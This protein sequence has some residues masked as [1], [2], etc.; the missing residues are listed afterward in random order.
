MDRPFGVHVMDDGVSLRTGAKELAVSIVNGRWHFTMVVEL[1]HYTGQHSVKGRR[2]A[3]RLAA[4][5]LAVEKHR[6]ENEQ[7]VDQSGYPKPRQT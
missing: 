4:A 7:R 6:A 5:L 2:L 1:T 3:R